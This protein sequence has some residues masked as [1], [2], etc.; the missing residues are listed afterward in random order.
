MVTLIG[1]CSQPATATA[2]TTYEMCVLNSI[3]KLNWMNFTKEETALR[4]SPRHR[5]NQKLNEKNDSISQD[6]KEK[7]SFDLFHV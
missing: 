2:A 7:H 6:E 3:R 4:V 1:M 5:Q